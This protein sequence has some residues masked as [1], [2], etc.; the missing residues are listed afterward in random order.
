MS[1]ELKPCPFCGSKAIENWSENL[2]AFSIECNTTEHGCHIKTPWFTTREKAIEKWNT[3]PVEEYLTDQI[4]L[5]RSRK[6]RAYMET[7]GI[8]RAADEIDNLQIANDS[9]YEALTRR[10]YRI[11]E[12]TRERDGFH[13]DAKLLG[14]SLER[15]NATLAF[16]GSGYFWGMQ[17][18]DGVA[19]LAEAYK[20]CWAMMSRPPI[21]PDDGEPTEDEE[22]N[23]AS[24]DPEDVPR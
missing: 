24:P 1:D 18:A 4:A 2:A 21:P 17:I 22:N 12:L 23:A 10:E 14:K 9:L 19:A 8:R 11:A 15:I 16:V 13:D 7:A 5:E 3:R 6:I 20:K